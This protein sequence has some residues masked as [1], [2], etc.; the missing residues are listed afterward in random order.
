LAA[1]ASVRRLQRRQEELENELSVRQKELAALGDELSTLTQM[2]PRNFSDMEREQVKA[3]MSKE[4][5]VRFKRL[6]NEIAHLKAEIGNLE[7]SCVETSILR[8]NYE[9]K[10]RTYMP[11]SD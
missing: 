3:F 6:S 1:R 7:S 9:S 8:Q 10:L 5:L 11:D 4:T 2:D